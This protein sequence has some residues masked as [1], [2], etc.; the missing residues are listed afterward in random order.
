M[1]YLPATIK[2]LIALGC[3][4]KITGT[5]LPATLKECVRLAVQKDVHL[6]IDTGNI[7]PSTAKELARLGGKNLTLIV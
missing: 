6:T 7:L 4:V 3:N 1:G 2:E 5:H